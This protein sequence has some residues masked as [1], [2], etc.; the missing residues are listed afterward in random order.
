MCPASWVSC[1]EEGP[2]RSHR[3]IIGS[4]ILHVRF[5]NPLPCVQS[6]RLVHD[7]LVKNTGWNPAFT[8]LLLQSCYF[9]QTLRILDQLLDPDPLLVVQFDAWLL[10]SSVRERCSVAERFVCARGENTLSCFCGCIVCAEDLLSLG[11]LGVLDLLVV[12]EA[13]LRREVQQPI[14]V[15]LLQVSFSFPAAHRMYA[16]LFVRHRV[17]HQRHECQLLEPSQYLQICELGH[18]VLAQDKGVQR[19]HA[20]DHARL[21]ALYPVPRA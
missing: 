18:I 15:V 6:S 4:F 9:R 7:V 1:C 19:G 11:A 16:Y 17:I 20:L 10:R 12:Q 21:N 8:D 13:D 14:P 5:Q 2:V 3:L